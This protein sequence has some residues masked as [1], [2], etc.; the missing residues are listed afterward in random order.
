M[1]RKGFCL[2]DIIV[3]IFLLSITLVFLFPMINNSFSYFNRAKTSTEMI[4]IAE[5]V[6]E[7]LKLDL[8][9]NEELREGLEEV[10]EV[11]Y[12]R[13]DLFD[14]SKYE[15]K[16]LS[17]GSSEFLWNFKLLIRQIDKGDMG[18]DIELEGTIPKI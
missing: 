7:A 16:L 11:D 12:R 17:Q 2:M 10:G 13:F 5:S 1:L 9:S 3:G 8:K 4:Y 14:G 6:M 18:Y 15:C